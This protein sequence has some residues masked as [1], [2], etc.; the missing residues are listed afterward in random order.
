MHRLARTIFVSRRTPD[1]KC[2]SA[3]G[4]SIIHI[5]SRCRPATT[6]QTGGG[7]E[8]GPYTPAEQNYTRGPESRTITSARA[9]RDPRQRARSISLRWFGPAIVGGALQQLFR[10]VGITSDGLPLSCRADST[11]MA[12]SPTTHA[13]G[14][15]S[16]PQ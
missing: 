5:P 1:V 2:S 11:S 3:S 8:E 9:V 4:Q 15:V 6:I 7:V 13:S 14:A 12:L 10:N 16:K